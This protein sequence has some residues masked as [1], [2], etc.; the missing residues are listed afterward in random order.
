MHWHIPNCYYIW[1]L[2]L[3]VSVGHLF[4]HLVRNCPLVTCSCDGLPFSFS[5]TH[6]DGKGFELKPCLLST[7][8]SFY[9]GEDDRGRVEK[10]LLQEW[11]I[12]LHMKTLNTQESCSNLHLLLSVFYVCFV[13]IHIA[14]FELK[15]P[16]WDF[17][18][19]C[20]AGLFTT[21]APRKCPG[22]PVAH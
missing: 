2:I 9:L 19:M 21:R 8:I 15:F 14:P 4:R 3:D 1:L 13:Y 12:H 5:I 7:F 20:S 16:P 11:L 6:Q 10:G 22:L 18:C 17:K